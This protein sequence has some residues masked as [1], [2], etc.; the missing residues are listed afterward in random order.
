M[1]NRVG[2]RELSVFAARG[3][4]EGATQRTFD[5]LSRAGGGRE[6]EPTNS[7]ARRGAPP[8]VARQLRVSFS[9]WSFDFQLCFFLCV[10]HV[11]K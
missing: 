3:T 11:E 9:L 2:I 6:A 5:W 10:A 4:R 1:S 8:D 7:N